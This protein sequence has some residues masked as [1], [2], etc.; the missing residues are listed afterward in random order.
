MTVK[1][2]CFNEGE[3]NMSYK[4]DKTYAL[5]VNEGS[6]RKAQNLYIIVHET[7][8]P[9]ATGLNEATFMK[10]NW[11]SAYT[12]F[13]VGD[14][15]VY[16]VGEPGFVAYGAL[17]ANPF[18]PMQVEL[19]HA[20]DPAMFKK[21]YPIYIEL[22]RDF[23]KKYGIPLTLD[24]GGKGTKGVKSHLWVTQNYGGSHTDPY[25]YLA[26]MGISKAQFAK[27]IANGISSKPAPAP[28]PKPTPSKKT[29]KVKKSAWAW[30]KSSG[31]KRIPDWVKGGTFELAEKRNYK[32]DKS[33]AEY[34]IKNKGVFLGAILAQDIEGA[35]EVVKAKS[36][37]KSSGIKWY[38][39]KG[40][41]T[42]NETINV[43][44]K[45]STNGKVVAQYKKGQS[46]IYDKFCHNGGYVWISYIS[47]SGKRRYM[48]TG[49]SKN[50]KRTS[51]WGT[52]R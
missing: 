36:K 45:P 16:L 31:G 24:A 9:R 35:T 18:S 5:G 46:V 37:P 23:A 49:N 15:K 30:S 20:T 22:I 40:T 39:E 32:Q 21:N 19:Q 4:I 6:P 25:G 50:G 43:R 28:K 29:V 14:G 34:V 13:I 48:A 8:N 47:N 12:H 44:D 1:V 7:A 3:N 52:F 41:F 38:A 17:D 42:A 27:D 26:K 33:T 51:Y 10:R 11:Y 2:V